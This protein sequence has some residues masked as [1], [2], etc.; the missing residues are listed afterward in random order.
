[1]KIVQDQ[2]SLKIH[3]KSGAFKNSIMEIPLKA[4]ATENL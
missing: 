4:R 1:M 3:S 2:V